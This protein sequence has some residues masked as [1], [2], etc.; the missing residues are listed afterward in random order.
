M[1]EPR[2]R[3]EYQTCNDHRVLLALVASPE[4]VRFDKCATGTPP[5]NRC[6]R[7]GTVSGRVG[8][9]GAVTHQAAPASSPYGE[10]MEPTGIMRTWNQQLGCGV[11]DSEATPGGASATIR[12]EASSPSRPNL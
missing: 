7:C 9:Q 5:R 10:R 11:I 2:Y 3:G 4:V 8:V 1:E 12:V 6:A